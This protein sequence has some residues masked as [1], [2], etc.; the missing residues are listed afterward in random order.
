TR[1]TATR[2]AESEPQWSPDGRFLAFARDNSVWALE[3]ER[4]RELQ[5]TVAGGD[6]LQPASIEWA[7]DSRHVAVV[8]RDQRGQR[9]LVVPNYLGERVATGSVKEGYSD[10]GVRV[11][12]TTWLYDD[13]MRIETRDPFPVKAVRL[14]AG[15]HPQLTGVAWSPDASR[16]AITD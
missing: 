1:L 8:T 4:G 11:V 13:K 7:P 16:L 2:A 15:K 5:L 3:V 6:S 10:N 14:G 9:D 12:A